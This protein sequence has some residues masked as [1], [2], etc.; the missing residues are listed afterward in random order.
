MEIRINN[1]FCL[2]RKIGSGSFGEIFM[3]KDLQYDLEVSVK[4][5]HNKAKHPQLLHE[6]R[7]YQILQ[8]GPGIPDF[9]WFGTEGNY[10][11]LVTELL[12]PSLEDL[13]NYCGRT[14]SVKTTLLIAEQM[15]ARLEFIHAKNLLHRDV[16]PENFLM[17][18][19]RKHITM[20]IIDFGL[21]KKYKDP[22]NNAHIPYVEGKSLT[23]TARYASVNTHVGIEQSR[24]DDLEGVAY[25]LFYFLRGSLPWQGS[26]IQN[27]KEKYD[28]IKDLKLATMPEELGRGFPEEFARLLEYVRALRFDE[29]PDYAYWK[30]AFKD[31]LSAEGHRNDFLY[32]WIL[33][34]S[35]NDEDE[36]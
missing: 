24:R 1:R 2:G 18:L 14:F 6:S 30:K 22:K 10:N 35:Q 31:R 20:H 29:R 34:S 28:M 8:G 19:G 23:G 7:V 25:V 15:I 33:L 36:Q 17:G 32:D 5:E 13:F 9:Y 4:L 21:A 26:N 12:G 3:G 27:K 16:K 11:V